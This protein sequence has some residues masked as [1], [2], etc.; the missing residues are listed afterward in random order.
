LTFKEVV[1]EVRK[2]LK[3]NMNIHPPRPFDLVINEAELDAKSFA[4]DILEKNKKKFNT[5]YAELVAYEGKHGNCNVSAVT[6]EDKA[7]GKWLSN[8]R[9]TYKKKEAGDD[10]SDRRILTEDQ[11]AKLGKFGVVWSLE[12]TFEEHFEELRAFKAENNERCPTEK[13]E[14]HRQ[15]YVWLCNTRVAY[16]KGK[17]SKSKLSDEQRKLF[18]TIGLVTSFEEKLEELRAFKGKHNG[19]CPSGSDG[20]V[21]KKLINWVRNMRRISKDK[22]DGKSSTTTLTDK[23]ITQFERIGL[24]KKAG[25]QITKQ[26]S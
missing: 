24:T 6:G 8:T 25:R 18:A 22:Q 7:L 14:G 15:L 21:H 10:D 1:G 11:I 26:S 16:K 23:Q 4:P 9:Q 2:V 12:A 20:A 5:R 19:R 13:D 3:S 17:S